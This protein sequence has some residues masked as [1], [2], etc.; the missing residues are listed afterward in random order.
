[1]TEA[2]RAVKKRTRERTESESFD[3]L[4]KEAQKRQKTNS[5][6]ELDVVFKC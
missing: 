2:K 1:M 5:G 6:I 3:D 4:L